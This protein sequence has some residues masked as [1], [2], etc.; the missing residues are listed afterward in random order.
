M[1]T[2]TGSPV[3]AWENIDRR[4]GPR[5]NPGAFRLTWGPAC[6]TMLTFQNDIGVANMELDDSIDP[7]LLER[8]EEE[9]LPYLD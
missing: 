5:N 1:L 9:T 2:W 3:R 6:N 8:W 4:Q 7:R